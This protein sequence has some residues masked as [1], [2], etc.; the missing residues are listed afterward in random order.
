MPYPFFLYGSSFSAPTAVNSWHTFRCLTLQLG[1]H[2]CNPFHEGREGIVWTLSAI[3][4]YT[5]LQCHALG[6]KQVNPM[7]LHVK[8]M[9]HPLHHDW[10]LNSG[11]EDT[12][13]V[14]RDISKHR[15]SCL[16]KGA[17]WL[18]FLH[19][20]VWGGDQQAK[21]DLCWSKW[22]WF[23]TLREGGLNILVDPH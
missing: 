4:C 15:E 10:A 18:F 5:C 8:P 9:M 7:A 16:M 21:S 6:Q 1:A 13:L 11:T 20:S 17:L 2:S 3:N 22:K 23:A 12:C 19:C 14:F